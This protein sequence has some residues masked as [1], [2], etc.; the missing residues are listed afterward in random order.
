MSGLQKQLSLERKQKQDYIDCCAKTNQ[1]LSGLHQELSHSLA[2]VAREP[3]ATVLES[4]TR[5]LDETLNHSLALG[6]VG[7]DG[8][9]S[10]NPLMSSTPK[11]VQQKGSR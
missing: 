9:L 1:E 6:A 3:E 7:W 4:E 11:I 10:V 5:K 8:L 2:A